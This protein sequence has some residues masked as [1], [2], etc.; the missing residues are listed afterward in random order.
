MAQLCWGWRYYAKLLQHAQVIDSAQMFGKL[1][2]GNP[3]DV[4]LAPC[5]PLPGGRNAVK[6]ALLC[7][8]RR[9]P[10]RSPVAFGDQILIRSPSVSFSKVP[11]KLQP[12]LR[13]RVNPLREHSR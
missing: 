3:T 2:I 4:H 8:L 6:R 9:E 13:P 1:L 7:A 5:R 10:R 11:L 12:W